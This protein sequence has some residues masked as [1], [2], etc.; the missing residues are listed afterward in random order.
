MLLN[1]KNI[2]MITT[3]KLLHIPNILN[4]DRVDNKNFEFAGRNSQTN[5]YRGDKLCGSV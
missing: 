1:D 2:I 3:K 4:N 5:C